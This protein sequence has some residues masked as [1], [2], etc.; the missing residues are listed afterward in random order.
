MRNQ[1]LTTMSIDVHRTRVL[2]TTYLAPPVCLQLP[3]GKNRRLCGEPIVQQGPIRS[4][5]LAVWRRWFPRCPP[6]NA[7]N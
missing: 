6:I 5:A 7:A 4:S 3:W 1:V 2:W